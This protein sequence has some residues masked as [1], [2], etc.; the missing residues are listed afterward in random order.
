MAQGEDLLNISERYDRE[1]AKAEKEAMKR[2]N[3][4]YDASYRQLITELRQAYG[5]LE[6]SGSISAL[7]RKGAILQELSTALEFI[8]PTRTGNYQAIAES[9]IQQ[10]VISGEGLSEE[11]LRYLGGPQRAFTTVPIGAVRFQA[12]TFTRRL[13]NYSTQQ[14]SQISA[15]IEQ[16]L[17]QGWGV[18]KVESHLKGL[19]V[20][21]KSNAETVA[22]TEQMSAYNGAALNRYEQAGVEYLQWIA[23]PSERLCV[24]CGERNGKIY[25]AKDFPQIPSHPRCRCSSVP[26]LSAED[27]DTEFYE[28]YRQEGLDDLKEQG[29]EP[30]GG[31]TYWEKKAGLTSAPKPVWTPGQPLPKLETTPIV[32]TASTTIVPT[33]STQAYPTKL[34][35]DHVLTTSTRITPARLDAALDAIDSPGAQERVGMFRDFVEKTEVQAVFV[36]TDGDMDAH[37]RMAK[38][39]LKDQSF[40]A[41]EPFEKGV[42]PLE[43]ANGF[44]WGPYNHVVVNTDDSPDKTREPLFTP[45][46]D[47]LSEGAKRALDGAGDASPQEMAWTMTSVMRGWDTQEFSTYLHEMGHQVHFKAGKPS[48]PEDIQGSVTDYGSKNEMEWFAEHF[49]LWMLDADAYEKVD[50]VGAQFIRDTLEQATESADI[51]KPEFF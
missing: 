30:D 10:S 46:G 31:M 19:G 49:N 50:P 38:Q 14:A 27:I 15:V 24:T 18:R 36:K 35:A 44:T 42:T 2:I 29:L 8:D 3:A 48:P 17:I 21:F 45:R 32:P 12:E 7:V 39:A 1:L 25:K 28:K 41:F 22:R 51:M 47:K 9:L 20:S 43:N 33:A 37:V 34:P 40:T 5:N 16:G 23:L 13:V 6:Q 4:A 11:T 26:V